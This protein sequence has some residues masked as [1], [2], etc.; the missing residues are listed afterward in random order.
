MGIK[1]LILEA[2]R[3]Y[4]T[5]RFLRVVTKN[6]RMYPRTRV[7]PKELF[8]LIDSLMGQRDRPQHY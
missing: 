8:F 7:Q 2:Q 1:A 6:A 4:L 5:F 3:F